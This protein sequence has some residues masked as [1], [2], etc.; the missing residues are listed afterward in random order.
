MGGFEVLIVLTSM[1]AGA[2]L[3]GW[4]YRDKM[5]ALERER[6]VSEALWIQAQELRITAAWSN[7][8]SGNG[9]G[10]IDWLI[11][12]NAEGLAPKPLLFGPQQERDLRTHGRAGVKRVDRRAGAWAGS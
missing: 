4:H 8:A 11:S 7:G 3:A 2:G 9:R 12:G 10:T 1:A 6:K 5:A